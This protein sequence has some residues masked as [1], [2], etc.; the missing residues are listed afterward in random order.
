VFEDYAGQFVWHCHILEHEDS[1]M[2]RPLNTCAPPGLFG[3][4]VGSIVDGQGGCRQAKCTSPDE[5]V[6]YDTRTGFMPGL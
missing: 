3:S 4:G 6:L 1:D 5:T 2:M